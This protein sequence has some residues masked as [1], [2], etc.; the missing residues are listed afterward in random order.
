MKRLTLL[1]TAAAVALTSLV[2]TPAAALGQREKDVIGLLLGLAV[3]GTIANEIDR[4]HRTQPQPQPQPR[5]YPQPQ[6]QPYRPTPPIY[7]SDRITYLPAACVRSVR[8]NSGRHDVVSAQCLSEQGVRATL[9]VTCAFD[10]RTDW[11]LQRVY[12]TQCLS[13]AGFRVSGY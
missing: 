9:P 12:G 3:I 13:D 6:P 11:G 7:R 4:S 5:W 10:I 1:T 8:L 2:A